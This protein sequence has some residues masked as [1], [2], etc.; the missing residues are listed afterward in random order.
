M[1]SFTR[2]TESFH[3]VLFETLGSSRKRLTVG[4]AT[5]LPRQEV[6]V[7]EQAAWALVKAYLGS[8]LGVDVRVWGPTDVWFSKP[9]DTFSV[10]ALMTR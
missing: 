3:F 7:I 4:R 10:D 9:E 6:D 8:D 2:L 5:A 1:N